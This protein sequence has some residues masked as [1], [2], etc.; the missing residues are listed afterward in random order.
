MHIQYNYY[1][2]YNTLVPTL[3]LP[4]N[5]TLPHVVTFYCQYFLR[6]VHVSTRIVKKGQPPLAFKCI[7]QHIKVFKS[8]HFTLYIPKP[9]LTFLFTFL[10]CQCHMFSYIYENDKC[11]FSYTVFKNFIWSG[12]NYVLTFKINNLVQC[13]YCVHACFYIV[14]IFFVVLLHLW[15]ISVITFIITLLTHL[16]HLNPPLNLPISPNLTR[17]HL[18]SSRCVLQYNMNTISELYLFLM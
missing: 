7:M 9:R 10:Q 4:L 5:L 2:N 18:N 17:I 3:N 11:N 1:S 6:E 15:L 16:L 8:W 13:T 12:L 14:L